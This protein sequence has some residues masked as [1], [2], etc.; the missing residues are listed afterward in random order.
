MIPACQSFPAEAPAPGAGLQLPASPAQAPARSQALAERI[1]RYW[2]RRSAGFGQVRRSEIAGDKWEAW[3]GE[4]LPWLPKPREGRKLAVLDVGTGP[5]FFAV[6]LACETGCEATGIDLSEGMLR[7]ARALAREAGCQARFLHMD[8]EALDFEDGTFDAVLV[9]NL[10][11]TLQRPAQAYREWCRVLRPGGVLLNFD[12]DYGAVDFTEI[13]KAE[14]AHAHAGIAQDL[15]QE[16]EDIRRL[17]PL[18]AEPRPQW[19][20]QAL[21]GAG[22]ASVAL[23]QDLSSRVFR[24]RDD[25]YNPVPMFA[26]RAVK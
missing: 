4:I 26:L 14:G 15:L 22:F 13:A 21:A 18:S 16:G 25:A 8:A 12:A 6:L 1:E 11:W 23:D 9:R 24:V 19:D 10:T 5:G 2:T 17:L 7:E 3:R 20:V